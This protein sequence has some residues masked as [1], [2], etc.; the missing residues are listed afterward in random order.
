VMIVGV[1][2]LGGCDLI[3]PDPLPPRGDEWLVARI[4]QTMSTE[5]RPS[6]A[7]RHRSFYRDKDG[8]GFGDPKHVVQAC[9][10]PAGYVDNAK[11]CYDD[12]A[13]AYPGQTEFFYKDRGDGSFDY[14]CDGQ[15]KKRIV[16]RAFCREKDDGSG[17][18]YASGWLQRKI[19]RC[20]EPGRWKWYECSQILFRSEAA[21]SAV[22]AVSG[23]GGGSPGGVGTILGA[24]NGPRA[25]HVG[26]H[27]GSGAVLSGHGNGVASSGT[28]LQD[29]RSRSYCRGK[30]MPWK[31]RQL[32]R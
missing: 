17:C 30:E 22:G 8:D 7:C 19:P 18:S 24:S 20:G 4:A 13:Q 21:G 12:N 32:C 16:D 9:R 10:A 6:G 14:D 15:A 29:F 28:L 25:S 5:S 3:R 23:Q 27:G 11:D 2:G 26:P 31:K 1:I